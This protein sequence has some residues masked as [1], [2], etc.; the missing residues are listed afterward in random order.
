MEDPGMGAPWKLRRGWARQAPNFV[1]RTRT[2]FDKQ[3]YRDLTANSGGSRNKHSRLSVSEIAPGYSGATL[4][5][6]VT[7]S[8]PKWW[9]V[10]I[11]PVSESTVS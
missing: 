8:Q 9:K 10:S 3:A 7:F 2:I 4:F 11:L 6:S 1:G 5:G